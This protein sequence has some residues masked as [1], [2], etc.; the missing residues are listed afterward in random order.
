MH[1]ISYVLINLVV[2]MGAIGTHEYAHYKVGKKTDQGTKIKGSLFPPQLYT[3][4]DGSK[5]QDDQLKA[6]YISGVVA[7]ALFIILSVVLTNTSQLF[8]LLF[9]YSLG[10]RTDIKN[11]ISL[12]NSTK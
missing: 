2:L 7:G 3:V 11:F 4:T 6:F 8:F 12:A 5:M 1:P 10:C 9:P